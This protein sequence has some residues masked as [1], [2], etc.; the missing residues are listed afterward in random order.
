MRLLSYI[1]QTLSAQPTFASALNKTSIDLNIPIKFKVS[2]SAADCVMVVRPAHLCC[3]LQPAEVL[4]IIGFASQWIYWIAT[5][6]GMSPLFP[7]R[8]F[9]L[10]S[11]AEFA[12]LA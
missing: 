8:L 11:T 1:F 6:P 9:R 10:S 3:D 5:T 2:G 4:T 12:S 7:V